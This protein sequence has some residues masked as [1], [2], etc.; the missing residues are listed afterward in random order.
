MRA[1]RLIPISVWN[2]TY[3][4][5]LCH[6]QLATLLK[7]P[8]DWGRNKKTPQHIV[9]HLNKGHNVLANM[10]VFQ[11]SHKLPVAHP[12]HIPWLSALQDTHNL[13]SRVIMPFRHARLRAESASKGRNSRK[14]YVFCWIYSKGLVGCQRQSAQNGHESYW[15][16]I[17]AVGAGSCRWCN[18]IFDSAMPAEVTPQLSVVMESMPSF[19][20]CIVMIYHDKN[21]INAMS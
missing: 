19:R 7:N 21:L 6:W 14:S 18:A 5:V 4:Y 13:P 11:Q 20:V 1:R 9:C 15:V 3:G 12:L 16:L 17:C 10:G 2:E 8:K